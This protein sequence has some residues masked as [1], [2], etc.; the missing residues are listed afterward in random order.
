MPESPQKPNETLKLT[1]SLPSFK[2]S[3]AQLNSLLAPIPK[4]RNHNQGNSDHLGRISPELWS[5]MFAYLPLKDLCT[6]LVVCKFWGEKAKEPEVTSALCIGKIN[7][8]GLQMKRM[9]FSQLNDTRSLPRLLAQVDVSSFPIDRDI[10]IRP[11]DINPE[12]A[13]NEDG[14]QSRLGMGS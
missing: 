12:A 4:F 3:Q 11:A 7:L 13:G 6:A 10:V 8:S 5:Q 14:A 2:L 9:F 1:L